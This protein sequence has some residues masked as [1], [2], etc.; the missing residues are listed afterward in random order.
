MDAK[1]RRY[2]DV[3]PSGYGTKQIVPGAGENAGD[4][5]PPA[6]AGLADLIMGAGGAPEGP[7]TETPEEPA[8]EDAA[9][10]AIPA[11]APSGRSGGR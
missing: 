7:A 2:G 3:S 10:A 9:A 8:A 5:A 6:G 11:K 1:I 4:G